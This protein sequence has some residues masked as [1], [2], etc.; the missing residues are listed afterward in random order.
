MWAATHRVH[1]AR[2]D[3]HG[4]PHTPNDGSWWSH[5]IWLFLNHDKKCRDALYQRYTPDLLKDRMLVFFEKTYGP[6]LILSGVALYA[7]G[8]LALAAVGSLLPDVRRLPLDVVREFGNPYLGLPQLRDRRPLAE[9]VVG[10]A[11]QLRR[12]L[13][14]QPPQRISAAGPRRPQMVGKST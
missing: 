9:P 12:R 10:R 4:D 13:A 5:I 14:Q 7:F 1:H 3:L 2:S 8:R 11:A 6:I